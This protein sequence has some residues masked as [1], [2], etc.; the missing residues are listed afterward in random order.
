M[1][2][3]AYANSSGESESLLIL[4]G[5]LYGG[6]IIQRRMDYYHG[7]ALY[8]FKKDRRGYACIYLDL[9]APETSTS[10]LEDF[11]R[12]DS[13]FGLLLYCRAAAQLSAR[14]LQAG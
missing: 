3:G 7:D 11:A 10:R 14:T 4:G 12:A 1:F 13:S 2:Q 6:R 9:S 5:G 8:T